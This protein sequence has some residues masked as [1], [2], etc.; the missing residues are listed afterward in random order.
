[1]TRP[2]R[3]MLAPGLEIA[4]VVTGLWQVA[5]MERGG[6]LL[7]PVRA[8]ADMAGYAAAGFDS[9]DMADHY[10]S[11]EVITGELLH[12]PG[13][14]GV[15]AFTK[16]CPPPGPMTADVVRAGVQRSLERM[17][18]HRIDLLQFHWWTFEHPGWLDA[19]LE[20][21]KLQD[22]GLVG[23]IGL[24]NFDT[25]HLRLLL[26]EGVPVASNQVCISLLDRRAT[27]AMQ[28]LCLERGVRLL[29]YGT[30]GG[31]FLSERWLGAEAPA[32]V[33]DWSKMKY[34]RF[35]DAVGGWAALQGVLRAA[36]AIAKKHGVSIANVATRWVLEQP[37][38][39]A[40]I[41]GARLGEREHR[42]DNLRL[43]AFSL[44]DD[45]RARLQAAFDG[46]TRIPGDCGDEYR[47]PPFLT[48]SGDLS[49]HLDA[50]P[51]VW[52]AVPMPARPERLRV[53]SGSVWEPLAGYSRAV[54]VGDR[55]LVSGTTATHGS[56][57][58]VG[59]D[60]AG[61]QAVYI[62]DKIAAS[63]GALGGRLED[64]VRTRVYLTHASDW[65]A[66]SEVH[67]RYFGDIRPA[68]TL[69]QVGALVGEGYR[70]EIE[71]EAVVT[72]SPPA[73]AAR[74]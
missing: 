65:R 5:D 66:V 13:G 48:A 60:D 46:T 18:T 39:A 57:R 17:R 43:F 54:R 51:P 36:D 33:G 58:V 1:M 59:G 69:L 34:R 15:R 6:T 40:V 11:A 72:P 41:V 23:A 45:D 26:A 14:Q 16:W 29:A 10:G 22:E 4:R 32:E 63:L 37:A 24:T 38:V 21:A 7:D 73:A 61:A 74:G 62:L 53:D 27:E 8:A 56:G 64:V 67:G 3:V 28:A 9:F 47:K 70:V 20:L 25:A 31:G 2:P 55:I 42:A 35:I 30:L 50:L 44:D 12:S 68:N 49:H 19:M 52:P 71:A